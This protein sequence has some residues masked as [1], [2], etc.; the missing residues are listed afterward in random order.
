[1]KVQVVEVDLLRKRIGLTMK[2]GAAPSRAATPRENH[3]EQ[4]PKSAR[5]NTAPQSSAMA[6]AFAKLQS[7]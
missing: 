2:M 3:F 1:M 6:S 7:L 5:Q 4:A